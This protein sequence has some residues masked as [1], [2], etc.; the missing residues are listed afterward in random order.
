MIPAAQQL[1]TWLDKFPDHAH[2]ALPRRE[3]ESV[4]I[5]LAE[6]ERVSPGDCLECGRENS[7][8][9]PAE[10]MTQF[11]RANAAEDRLRDVHSAVSL[12]LEILAPTWPRR[13]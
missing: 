2:L 11:E 9:S 1:R 12:I 6:L 13:S 10:Y 5:R 3:L 7:V 8:P 4:L